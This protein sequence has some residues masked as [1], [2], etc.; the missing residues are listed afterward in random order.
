MSD[1]YKHI[2]LPVSLDERPS[3]TID[4]EVSAAHWRLTETRCWWR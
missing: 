2:G 4:W 3:Y 1:T